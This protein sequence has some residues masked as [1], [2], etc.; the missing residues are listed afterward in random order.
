MQRRLKIKLT[1]LFIIVLA[2]QVIAFLITLYD[3]LLLSSEYSTGFSHFYNYGTSVLFNALASLIGSVMGGSFLVFYVNE[4][5][6]ERSYGFTI[7]AVFTSFVT[8]VILIT[9]LFG[10]ITALIN[11]GK[12]LTHPETLQRFKT[13]ILNPM[14]FKNIV[15]W[16]VVVAVTQLLLSIDLKFG[17][18]VL[19]N[20]IR[21]KYHHPRNEKRIFMFL[22]LNSSTSIA[23]KLGNEK[24]HQLLKD[25]FS[26][27]T[28]PVLDNRGEIYQYVGDEAVVSWPYEYGIEKAQCIHCYLDIRNRIDQK[29]QHYLDKYGLVPGFKA[30]IHFGTVIAGEIGVIKRDITFSGDVLNTT[31]RIQG[32]CKE[33]QVDVLISGEL[34]KQL[35]GSAL[36]TSR[37][38]GANK[39]RGKENDIELMTLEI[40]IPPIAS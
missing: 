30:G 17:P 33:L 1:K 28:N 15:V 35:P 9:I 12:P 25:F 38:M 36:Y 16:G 23:E 40:S 34:A 5:Y 20:F 13:H 22:D 21:G 24:Y 19:W 39:L 7:L 37:S 31:S 6:R 8:I 2:W 10:I 29:K 3:H 32:M 14:H 18:G 26:D 11:T 27:L 4:K